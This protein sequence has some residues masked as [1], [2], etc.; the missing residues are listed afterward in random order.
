VVDVPTLHEDVIAAAE[1]L[2]HGSGVSWAYRLLEE[3][4]A[5]H[6]LSDPWLVVDPGIGPGARGDR[7][8]A[9]AQLFSLHGMAASVDTARALLRRPP[10]LYDELA[11]LDGTLNAAIGV[12]SSAAFSTAA[13]SLRSAIDPVS[14]LSTSAVIR[15]AIARAAACAARYGWSSTL[16]LLTTG[17]TAAPEQRWLAL[18]AALRKALRS[19]DEA[20]M[21]APGV[22]LALLGNAGPDAVRPFIG[23]VRAALST[24]GWQDVDLHAATAR[25][26]EE[27]VDPAELARLATER[28]ADAGLD[29]TAM[30]AEPSLLELELRTLSGVVGVTM[31]TPILVLSTSPSAALHERV[32]HLVRTRL[33]H[34]SVRLLSLPLEGWAPEAGHES[35]AP[36][37][38]DRQ[39]QGNGHRR[40]SEHANGTGEAG[41]WAAGSLVARDS[42]EAL[43]EELVPR[44]ISAT[45]PGSDLA[46]AR[47]QGSRVTLLSASFDAAR[48]TSEVSLALGDRRGTGRAPA[49]PLAGGAQA[50]LNALSALSIDVPFYLVSAEHAHGVPGEPVVVV[51]AP[52]RETAGTGDATGVAERLGVA[53]GVA[54]VEAA[55]RATLGALNRHLAGGASPG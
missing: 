9:G 13:A 7:A 18:A 20:G 12:M 55:S 25:T 30:P 45:A 14:G 52:K 43:A 29:V 38:G 15:E 31:A 44:A 28:L 26:P 46:T 51:L 16:V 54:D 41:G 8:A 17:G 4:G 1:I 27:T 37:P 24:A 47:A 50:T 40:A 39:E 33:P 10:G 2:R 6:G 42:R 22:A 34:A 21:T 49:G 36:V 48:G 53:A 3:L 23:R 32:T 19:G 11:R 35:S 5:R